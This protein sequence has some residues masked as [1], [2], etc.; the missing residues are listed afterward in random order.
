MDNYRNTLKATCAD[1]SLR[2][3]LTLYDDSVAKKVEF[4]IV[5]GFN[6]GW[7]L[8]RATLYSQRAIGY[9]ERPLRFSFPE[10][11]VNLMVNCGLAL[12]AQELDLI[13]EVIEASV[14]RALSVQEP[15]VTDNLSANALRAAHPQLKSAPD[16]LS[17]QVRDAVRGQHAHDAEGQEPPFLY[18]MPTV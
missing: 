3:S 2:A 12:A 17:R 5:D 15:S 1:V 6:D 16:L 13:K 4:A 11:I 18:R 10:G 9:T 8:V 7:R 14:M